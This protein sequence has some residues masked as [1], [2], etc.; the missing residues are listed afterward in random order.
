[1]MRARAA[2]VCVVISDGFITAQLPA[3]MAPTSGA[4]TIDSG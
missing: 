4:H 1:M 2:D 3:A